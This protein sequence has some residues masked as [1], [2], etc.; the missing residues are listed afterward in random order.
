M[1]TIVDCNK[2]YCFTMDLH[3]WQNIYET[4]MQNGWEPLGTV[5]DFD[6]SDGPCC[7]ECHERRKVE[8][9]FM[10]RDWDGCY[11]T[12]INMIVCEEDSLSLCE[13]LEKANIFEGFRD[14]VMGSRFYIHTDSP[15]CPY[16]EL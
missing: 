13:A 5:L 16:S 12:G 15:A 11:F 7:M 10:N 1:I 3:E 9:L 4:G 6:D 8:A 14:F 2:E